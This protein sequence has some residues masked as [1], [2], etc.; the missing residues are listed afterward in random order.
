MGRFRC[1]WE[2]RWMEG[3][4]RACGLVLGIGITRVN[5]CED[6]RA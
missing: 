6:L 5:G 2:R 3:G 1:E 4:R